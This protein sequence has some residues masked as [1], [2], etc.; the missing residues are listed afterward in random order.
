MKTGS[1]KKSNSQIRWLIFTDGRNLSTKAMHHAYFM[2][3]SMGLD[4]EH[5]IAPDAKTPN[6]AGSKCR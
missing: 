1:E 2:S 4:S 5:D 3:N 6:I